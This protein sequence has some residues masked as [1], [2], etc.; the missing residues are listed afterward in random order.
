MFFLFF[1]IQNK[2][3]SASTK[4]IFSTSPSRRKP[5]KSLLSVDAAR[6]RLR[7]GAFLL[8]SKS[9]SHALQSCEHRHSNSSGRSG[10]RGEA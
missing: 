5:K 1:L 3:R 9:Q 10:D 7:V 4:E 2:K 8:L 6:C